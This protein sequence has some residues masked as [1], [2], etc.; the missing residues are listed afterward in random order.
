MVS[1]FPA[2]CGL[3][4]AVLFCGFAATSALAELD[5]RAQGV[6]KVRRRTCHLNINVSII[7][8]STRADGGKLIANIG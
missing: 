4:K 6:A 2:G 1:I 3:D 5:E 8:E 7:D